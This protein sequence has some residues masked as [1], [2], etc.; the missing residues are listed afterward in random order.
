MKEKSVTNEDL[1]HLLQGH[2]EDDKVAFNKIDGRLNKNEQICIQNGDHMSHIRKDLTE[3]NL[4]ISKLTDTLSS[5]IKAVEPI[6]TNY[7]DTQA[8]YR[9]FGRLVKPVVSWVLTIGSLIG[10]WFVIKSL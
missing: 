4:K 6:L 8:T 3:V 10:A 7:Q 2:F 9:T 5:H 1:F